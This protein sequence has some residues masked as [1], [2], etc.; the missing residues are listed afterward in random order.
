VPT[1]GVLGGAPGGTGALAT[2]PGQR[3]RVVRQRW[4]DSPR[5]RQT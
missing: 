4:P 3:G 5:S 2:N 1:H